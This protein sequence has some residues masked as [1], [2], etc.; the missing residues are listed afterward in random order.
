MIDESES[1][2]DSVSDW[3][4]DNISVISAEVAVELLVAVVSL[5]SSDILAVASVS[6]PTVLVHFPL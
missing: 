5:T 4:E 1:E 2:L 3:D 6:L